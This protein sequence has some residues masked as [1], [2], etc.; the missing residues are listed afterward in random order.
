MEPHLVT[1]F[2]LTEDEQERLYARSAKDMP[3][4]SAAVAQK[5][6]T[7][8]IVMCFALEEDE[9]KQLCAESA[10]DDPP[11]SSTIPPLPQDD[12]QTEPFQTKTDLYYNCSENYVYRIVQ[13]DTNDFS[14]VIIKYTGSIS[15]F[16][17]PDRLG[18]YPVT[19]IGDYAFSGCAFITS[20]AIPASITSIGKSA[21]SY[22]TSLTEVNMKD[23]IR[24]IGSLAFSYCT[25]LKEIVLPD[26]IETF[27]KKVFKGCGRIAV[28]AVP[29]SFIFRYLTQRTLMV[30]NVRIK[31]LR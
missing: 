2:A 24:S 9:K 26:S 16:H 13:E 29:S 8:H 7:Q 14:A 27:G 3:Q 6:H 20:L 10:K 22:C 21:F 31:A 25:S 5:S 19:K 17:V 30:S 11:V 15:S 4:K 23:S 18:G 12:E 1:C 28:Y